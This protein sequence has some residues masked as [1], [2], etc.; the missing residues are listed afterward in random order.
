MHLV[1][2][3][4]SHEIGGSCVECV[5]DDGSRLVLD[6]GLPLAPVLRDALLPRV[7]GMCP[8]G[9]LGPTGRPLA[10]L[11]SHAHLDH[12][13]LAP[14]ADPAIP[15]FA[16]RGTVAILD[17]NRILQP[18]VPTPA[19]PVVLPDHVPFRIGPFTVTALPV[20]HSA[21]DAQALLVEAGGRRLLY[22][23]DLRAH[24]RTG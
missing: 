17:V 23:G 5:T 15:V 1:I 20:D 4:G 2:H 11:L 24:G 3:R 13:G 14:H 21:P 9:D 6:L 18:D 12:A 7:P 8:P 22:S 16:S 10:L 19:R